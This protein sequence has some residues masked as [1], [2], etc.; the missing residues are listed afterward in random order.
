MKSDIFT[1][2]EKAAATKMMKE[3]V[4]R[5]LQ[6]ELQSEARRIV[7][8]FIRINMDSIEDEVTK[9]FE[10]ALLAATKNIINEALERTHL[11]TDEPR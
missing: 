8:K 6:N 1:K 3:A 7:R 10:A 5:E 2:A 11:Y 9:K 4:R